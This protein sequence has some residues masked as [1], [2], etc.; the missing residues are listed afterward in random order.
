MTVPNLT[1]EELMQ[2]RALTTLR[3]PGNAA[4]WIAGADFDIF[5]V[6]GVVIVTNCFGVCTT[7][8]AGAIVPFLEITTVVPVATVP[9][10]ALALTLNADPV[11]SIYGW[12]GLL[13][14]VLTVGAGVGMQELAATNTWTGGF[15]I[16]TDGVINVNNAIAST[17]GIIDWF[18]T[19]IPM[20][21]DGDITIL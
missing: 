20:S 6:T 21:A 5:T 2:T 7:L 13:A 19:F 9:M 17:A 10:C 16:L 15:L 12:S 18:I 14:G 11:D 3:R 1:R 8:I 4:E